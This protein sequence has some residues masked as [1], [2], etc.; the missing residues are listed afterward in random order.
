MPNLLN[1]YCIKSFKN[2]ASEQKAM[3]GRFSVKSARFCQ[4]VIFHKFSDFILV[5]I[6]IL[7]FS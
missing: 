5:N 2:A 4:V 1:S 6:T 7:I 3:L